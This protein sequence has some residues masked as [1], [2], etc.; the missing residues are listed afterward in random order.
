MNFGLYPRLALTGIRKNRQLYFPYLLTCAGMMFLYFIM[1]SLAASPIVAEIN[2]AATTQILLDL[3]KNVVAIFA[4]IFLFYTN[5]F[6]MRRR[7]REF[8]LYNV[9]GMSKGN[10]A[11]ILLWETLFTAAVG[12]L[13]GSLS[14]VVLYKLAELAL[15]R[16]MQGDVTYSINIVWSVLPQ[17]AL[18]FGGIF[19]LL[20]VAALL[21]VRLTYPI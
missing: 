4:A 16:I 8:G 15:V 9:L 12:L 13:G 11:C 20:F 14:G 18:L 19:L 6:L 3:G 1:A 2:G 10:I 17:T 5:S 21:R 7:Q